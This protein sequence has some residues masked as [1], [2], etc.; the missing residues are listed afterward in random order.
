MLNLTADAA[1][2]IHLWMHRHACLAHL[3]VVVYPS[4]VHG[5]AACADLTVKLLGKL[6]QHVEAFL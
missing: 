2:D 3:P 4:C 5:C 6:E 1:S